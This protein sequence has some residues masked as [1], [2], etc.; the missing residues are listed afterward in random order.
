MKP[1]V[2][3]G[4]ISVL[5][6]C[7][8]PSGLAE[9]GGPAPVPVDIRAGEHEGFS[10]LAFDWPMAVGHDVRHEGDYIIITFDRPGTMDVAPLFMN[11]DGRLV[12]ALVEDDGRRVLLQTRGRFDVQVHE[13]GGDVLVVDIGSLPAPGQAPPPARAAEAP[14]DGGRVRPVALSAPDVSDRITGGARVDRHAAAAAPTPQPSPKPALTAAAEPPRMAQ[15]EPAAAVQQDAPGQFDVDED[16]LDRALERTLTREGV[17]LLP[18]GRIEVTPSFSYSRRESRAPTQVDLFGLFAQVRETEIRRDEYTANLSLDIGLPFDSQLEIS[19][20]FKHIDQTTMTSAG[21]VGLEESDESADAFDDLVVGLAKGVL[22]EDRWWPDVVARVTWDTDTGDDR[23]GNIGLG[24]GAHELAGS[25]S[26]LKTRDP[27]AFFGGVSY[28]Y[29]FEEDGFDPGDTIGVS[30]GTSLA[31]GPDTSL[32]LAL[33]QSFAGKARINDETIPGSQ[34]TS[35]S[36]TAGA[37]L[38]LGGGVLLDTSVT[39]GLTDD[40]PDYAARIA[41]PIRFNAL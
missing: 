6:L 30:I 2:L 3:L 19:Q 33:S 10:R 16:A 4:A 40:A 25:L 36:L 32:R 5:A 24:G 37:S 23:D 21:F 39:A 7:Q 29:S 20:S 38:I 18:A 17:L 14:R 28:G 1:D 15:A 13:G 41:L 35:A 31:A 27:L 9:T 8:P 11:L 12:G 22:Q 34:E 26:F